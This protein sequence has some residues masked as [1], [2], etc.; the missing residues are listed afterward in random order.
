MQAKKCHNLYFHF[1]VRSGGYSENYYSVH[2]LKF[3]VLFLNYYYYYKMCS[4]NA[5]RW[6]KTTFERALKKKRKETYSLVP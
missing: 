4:T 3:F 2:V 6:Q 5:V 1:S